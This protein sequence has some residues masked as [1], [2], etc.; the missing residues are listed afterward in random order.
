MRPDSSTPIA[1]ALAI[2]LACIGCREAKQAP[3][4]DSEIPSSPMLQLSAA[5]IP[6]MTTD[7]LD[8]LLVTSEKPVLVEFGVTTGCVR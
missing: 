4:A 2:L 7:E 8:R 3:R 6:D 1:A 5:G